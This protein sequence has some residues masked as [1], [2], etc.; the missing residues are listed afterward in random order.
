LPNNIIL[1]VTI[2]KFDP[3]L[4]FVNINKLNPYK[5]IEDKILQPVLVKLGGLVT[6]ELVQARE[7]IPLPVELED[8]QHVEFEPISS[9]LTHGS[10]KGT[11]V[12]VHHYHNFPVQ[13]NN[14]TMSN[15]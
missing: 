12:H 9:H 8:F 4:V 3:N 1:F 13:D 5:F 10:I 14:I 6:N 7:L 2:D 15:D 11:Y